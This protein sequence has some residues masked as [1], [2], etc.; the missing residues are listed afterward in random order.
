MLAALITGAGRVELQEFPSPVPTADGVVVDIAYCGVCGTD[1]GAYRTGRP[2]RPAVCGHEWTGTVSAIGASVTTV[3]EGDRVVVGVPQPCGWCPACTEGHRR[4]CTTAAA[5]AHGRDPGA[6]PHGGFAGA[7][8]V[9]A[10]RVIAAHPDLDDETLAQVEPVAVSVHAVNNRPVVPGD[11]VVVQGAGAVGLTTLQVAQAAGAAQVIVVEPDGDRRALASALGATTVTAPDQAADAV[12]DASAGRGADLVYEC[13]GGAATLQAAV[14]LCR[15]GG[16]VGLVGVSGDTA[17]IEPGAWIRKE[18]TVT[19]ALGSIHEEF[20]EAMA[21]LASGQ[22]RVEPLHTGT[23][24]LEGLADLFAELAEG[25]SGHLKVL[26]RP[27]W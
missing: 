11:V 9:S 24:R 16:S 26:V 2:Y 22:V 19:A 6:P 8:A 20:L 10:D 5:F 17:T 15:R 3:H 18:I 25:S 14:E 27:Q 1:V 21:L 4:Y 13:V 12:A 7:I 23:V